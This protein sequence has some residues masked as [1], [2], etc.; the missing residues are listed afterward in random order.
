M[1]LG[2]DAQGYL[3]TSAAARAGGYEPPSKVSAEAVGHLVDEA[4]DMLRQL[5][6]DG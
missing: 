6:A 1:E 5:R 4:L 2:G 3:V